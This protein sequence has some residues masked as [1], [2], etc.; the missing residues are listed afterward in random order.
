MTA[1]LPAA[2]WR[3]SAPGSLVLLWGP[4]TRDALALSIAILEVA[5]RNGCRLHRVMR[6]WWQF[7]RPDALVLIGYI[8]PATFPT[9]SLRAVR[10]ALPP[11]RQYG[12]GVTGIPVDEIGKHFL[13]FTRIITNTSDTGVKTF[14]LHKGYVD[15]VVLPELEELR[16]YVPE[17]KRGWFASTMWVLTEEG[18]GM[19]EVL[20]QIMLFGRTSF[21]DQVDVNPQRAREFVDLAGSAVLLVRGLGKS[22][23]RLWKQLGRNCPPHRS[24]ASGSTISLQLLAGW[25]VSE[26]GDDLDKALYSIVAELNRVWG[27]PRRGGLFLEGE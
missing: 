21:A 19:L 12:D 11:P 18:R 8:D 10:D 22:Y 14:D 16:I 17:R 5:V 15:G 3:L 7:F 25:Q 4:E 24:V 20:Q 13:E 23:R 6:P 2:P 9:Q 27:K 26:L 1:D